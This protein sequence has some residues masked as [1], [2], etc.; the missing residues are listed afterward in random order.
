MRVQGMRGDLAQFDEIPRGKGVGRRL[1][2]DIGRSAFPMTSSWKKQRLNQDGWIRP[3]ARDPRR[4]G[5]PPHGLMKDVASICEPPSA[6]GL[7]YPD[8][9]PARRSRSRAGHRWPT[10]STP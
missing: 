5:P 9:L 3:R 1:L 7:G 4:E 10:R 8:G 2:H 6:D